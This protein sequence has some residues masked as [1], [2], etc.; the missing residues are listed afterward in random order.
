MV[1]SAKYSCY[2]G[3]IAVALGILSHLVQVSAQP[4]KPYISKAPSYSDKTNLLYYIGP[5][6][7][8][9]GI[10]NAQDWA[11]RRSHILEHMQAVMG[12]FPDASRKVPLAPKLVEETET[13]T[14]IRQKWTIAVEKNDRLPVFALIPK[15]RTG[16]L[17]A[18]LCLHP[19]SKPLG[20]GIPTGFGDKPDRHYAVHLVNR[21]YVT[22]APDYVNM[23]EYRVDPYQM[24]Y[25]SATMKGIWNH[26]RCVDF[27]ETMPEVDAK[28]I[29]AIGHSLGGHNSIFL[30]VF[31][32]RIQCVVSS[33]GFCSFA[34]Y[35]KGDLTGWSH[36]GYMPRI[37]TEYQ[38]RPDRMPFEFTEVIGALAPRSFLA[39]APIHDSNFD[40]QGVKDCIRAAEPVYRLLGMPE[41]IAAVYPDAGHDFPDEARKTA[42]EWF[43]RWLKPKNH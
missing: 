40:V 38:R 6:G 9:K 1:F 2:G 14:Y 34:S 30:A 27:L 42:Y 5:D 41:K 23:G 20:K 13:P 24:G 7:K 10:R 4:V 16:K 43:D 25:E 11:I 31:D 15:N 29:G 26:M 3:A 39:C 33:C 12:Q 17:P 22:L 19:T 35:M 18:V 36:D 37:R 8:A 28:R 32:E 21:G